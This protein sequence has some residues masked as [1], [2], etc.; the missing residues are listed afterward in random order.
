MR[1]KFYRE[2]KY[3]SAALNNLE[4]LIAKTDFRKEDEI[5]RAR[6]AWNE[7]S[8]M[9]QNHAKYEEEKL[10]CLLERKGSTL[11][12]HAHSQHEE[13]DAAFPRIDVLFDAVLKETEEET[14]IE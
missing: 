8:H 12:L 5:A 3:V 10:H 13:M 11:H 9:L 7:L 6:N 4:R 2:H 1:V 14:R